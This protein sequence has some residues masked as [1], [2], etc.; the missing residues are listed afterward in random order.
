MA[1]RL[2]QQE[3]DYN[4]SDLLRL[5][6][7]GGLRSLHRVAFET[8]MNDRHGKWHQAIRPNGIYIENRFSAVN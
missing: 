2:N 8:T 4:L 6:C 1:L 5:I 7:L 3:K